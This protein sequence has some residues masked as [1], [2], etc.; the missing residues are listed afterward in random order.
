[1][2]YI[3]THM[4]V[5]M[6]VCMYVCTYVRMYVCMQSIVIYIG[7]LI[8]SGYIH[9][10]S[11]TLFQT[12]S[13]RGEDMELGFIDV[14][15]HQRRK[16][17]VQVLIH[18]HVDFTL[19]SKSTCKNLDQ[20]IVTHNHAKNWECALTQWRFKIST[21]CRS[22]HSMLPT[23]DPRSSWTSWL[24]NHKSTLPLSKHGNARSVISAWLSH[25][26]LHFIISRGFSIH[27]SWGILPF[28]SWKNTTF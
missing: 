11:M 24:T 9:E 15:H 21:T 25:E 4:Y 13:A 22:K 23:N 6:Y 18:N 5:W 26:N 14:H 3:Y 10:L 8:S 17:T 28:E 1:M 20:A 7:S 27:F 19:D 2:L 12:K 16:T